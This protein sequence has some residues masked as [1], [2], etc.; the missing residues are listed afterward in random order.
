MER[1]EQQANELQKVLL[2]SERVEREGM[3][4]VDDATN[5]PLQG[6]AYI[7]PHA[8]VS[9]CT[10]GYCA[11]EYDMTPVDFYAH[12][13][14]LMPA[15]HVFKANEVSDDYHVRLI[16]MSEAFM[17]KFKQLNIY[18]YNTRVDYYLANPHMHL[19]DEQFRQMN[20]AFDLL[21][22]VSTIGKHYREEMML[23]VFNTIMMMRYEF[24][25]IPDSSPSDSVRML[26][27]GF[28]QAVVDHYRESREV[29][30]Y[31][32][33]FNLSPKYF[34]MLI[35]QETGMTAGEWIDHY[36]ELQ[37]K[38]LLAHRRSLTIQQVSD[39]LGFTEQAAFS[40]FFK[41]QTGQSPSEFR[42]SH[43]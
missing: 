18:R 37:A 19:T 33:L 17:E 13:T 15:N 22:A 40:R 16:V 30:F 3:V 25:P 27:T 23:S 28:R 20:T 11:C 21:K 36:V 26:S 10:Q 5:M 31:A 9:L 6:D 12:D 14:V 7:S 43:T 41:K 24:C 4:V 29:C 35:R 8:A 34:S 32:R 2:V 39:L 1:T 42:E 38:S